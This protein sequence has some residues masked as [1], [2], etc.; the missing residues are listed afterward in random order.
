MELKVAR[1]V[2]RVSIVVAVI[3]TEIRAGFRIGLGFPL[4]RAI[5]LLLFALGVD[6]RR[7]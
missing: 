5:A 6:P 2:G 3:A 7:P 4:T 1:H